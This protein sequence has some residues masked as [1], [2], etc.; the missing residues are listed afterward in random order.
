MILRA[1]AVLSLVLGAATPALAGRADSM[2][3]VAA[4]DAAF[5]Q[6]QP[7]SARVLL[8]NATDA[9]PKNAIAWMY[10]TRVALALGD[11]RGAGETLDRAIDAGYPVRRTLH[12]RAHALVLV[13]RA[14]DALATARADRVAAP[15]RGYAARMRGRALA[16]L[17]DT[18]GAAREFGAALAITPRSVDLWVDVARFRL[19]TGERLGAIRASDQAIALDRSNVGALVLKGELVRDQYGLAASL[20]WFEKALKIDRLDLDA[21]LEQAATL[22]DMGRTREMLTVTRA[23]QALDPTNPQAFYL[24]AA[25]AARARNFALADKLIDQIG[26]ALDAVPG[27]L[28]LK[29]TVAYQ[30]GNLS[31]AAEALAQLV[32]AQPDN[33]TARRLL[34]STQWRAGDFDAVIATL[35]PIGDQ[36]GADSYSLTLMARAYESQGNRQ[37]ASLYLDRAATVRASAPLNDIVQP[38]DDADAADASAK[39][40]LAR[41][42]LVSGDIR[43]GLD[44]ALALQRDN[45]GAPDAH[46]LAGDAWSAAGRPMAAIEAYR[47]AANLR[48]SE[49]VALRM[50]AALSHIGRPAEAA[51]VLDLF[52]SQNPMSVRVRTLQADLLMARS[53]FADAAKVLED[54]RQR[55]GDGD[56]AVASNLAWCYYRT[57]RMGDALDIADEAYR[58][59]PANP[60]ISHS[61]GWI[62]YKSG[63]NPRGA[64]ALLRQAAAQAPDWP[65]ARAHLAE[66]ETVP[67][68]RPIG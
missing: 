1:L 55:V 63:R 20:P 40:A 6:G 64:L 59:A 17:G 9:D 31:E 33:V 5:A 41:R 48:F 50:I 27:M 21:Q 29:G 39:V 47:R 52:L 36:P 58:L 46:L 8:M 44:I 32:E 68:T 23:V 26:G 56:V 38:H 57:D 22:G 49:G 3:Y 12:L 25:L 7:R 10:Q 15:Y 43:Q 42:L 62:L 14:A 16:D 60:R 28:L 11:G 34:A 53:R 51:R 4:A 45:P 61:Y 54:L 37:T 30:L 13:G 19:M 67:A 66:A 24:Q 2:R 35:A 65:L 18:A